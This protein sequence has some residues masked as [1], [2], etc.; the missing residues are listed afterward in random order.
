MRV[1]L[2]HAAPA[3]LPIATRAFE[4]ALPGAT[5][6][7]LLDT[8]L[9][10]GLDGRMETRDRLGARLEELILLALEPEPHAVLVT[11]SSYPE[12]VDALAADE[13]SRGIPLLRP[14]AGMFAEARAAGVRRLGVV[15][16]LPDAAAAARYG[17]ERAYDG[18][19]PELAE[20]VTAEPPDVPDAAR[21]L[22]REHGADAVALAQFSLAPAAP[23]LAA[24]L[25]VP[26]LTAPDAAARL[27]ARPPVEP[28]RWPR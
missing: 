12:L 5:L 3:V 22:V 10:D 8:S 1:A 6:R 17:I 23:S 19:P 16:S 24:T 2:V 18:D 27:V 4:R 20:I 14:D 11:C 25:G 28:V 9:G 15:A 26:V 21:S 13:R 7:H